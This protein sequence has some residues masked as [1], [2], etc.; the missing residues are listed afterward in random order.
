MREDDVATVHQLNV[1]AF[2][3]LAGRQGELPEPPPPAAVAHIRYRH[4][5]R[6]DPGGAWVAED[7]RGIAGC[8][9]ALRRDDVWGLSLLFVRPDAQSGG[10]GSRLLRRA[11]EYADGARGRI[12]LASQDPRA[13]RAYARLGLAAHPCLWAS[14]KPCGVR[15][16]EGMRVG[17]HAD[18]P[19]TEAV[20]RH[21]RGA[22]HGADVEAWLEMGQ[23]LLIAPERGYA[24]LKDGTLRALAAFDDDGAR[25]VLR[26]VLARSGEHT[27]AVEWITATQ[28]WAVDVCLDAG[29]ELRTNTGAVFLDGD[30]GP[31]RPY[32]PSG[33]F[34]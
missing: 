1:E 3:D 18:I 22:A 7:E 5:V 28:Q 20:D 34:L 14:G 29:L 19:F 12:I 30:V 15:E 17:T 25:D 2:E 10:V 23:T 33:A 16:P 13:L 21:V 27:V 11:N 26:A 31:F 9:L 32:L 24:V 4:L 8:A 6:T